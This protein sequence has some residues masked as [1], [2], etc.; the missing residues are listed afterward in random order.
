MGARDRKEFIN[1]WVIEVWQSRWDISQNGR[2]TFE[3]VSS[4]VFFCANADLRIS[5]GLSFLLTGHASLNAFLYKHDTP[6]CMCGAPSE[7]WRHVLCD[8]PLNDDFRD[9]QSMCIVISA[10]NELDVRQA[11][12]SLVSAKHVEDFAFR[13][14]KRRQQLIQQNV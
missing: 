11:L 9:L 7:D 14:F 6:S 10:N 4:V 12:G 1:N 13:L 5:L 8:C 2:S 3:F